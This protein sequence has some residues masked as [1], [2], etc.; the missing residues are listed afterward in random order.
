MNERLFKDTIC[1]GFL[2]WLVGYAISFV[3]FFFVPPSLLGWAIMPFGI[4][5]T[6]WVLFKKVKSSDINY[7]LKLA[8][9]WTLLAIVLDYIFI[10]QLLKPADGYYKL[11]VY[12]YYIF[13]FALPLLIGFKKSKT[14]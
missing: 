12:F 4:T 13:T 5:I 3:L 2:L 14:N 9:V 7:Y 10:V 11:D 6:L 8:L 1:W